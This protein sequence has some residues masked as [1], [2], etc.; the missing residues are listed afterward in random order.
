M[1]IT[2][3]GPNGVNLVDKQDLSAQNDDNSA[4]LEW[5]VPRQADSGLLDQR[6]LGDRPHRFAEFPASVP[7]TIL[8][9]HVEQLPGAEHAGLFAVG[10]HGTRLCFDFRMYHF[11]IDDGGGPRLSLFVDAK[12]CDEIVLH[13]IQRYFAELLSPGARDY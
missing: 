3:I 10:A 13:L 6:F 12:D 7:W 9:D 5:A 1:E 2:A 8:L 11:C 4:S